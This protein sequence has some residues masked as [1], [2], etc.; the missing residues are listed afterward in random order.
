VKVEIITQT[1]LCYYIYIYILYCWSYDFCLY[2]LYDSGSGIHNLHACTGALYE[3]TKF[4]YFFFLTNLI[5]YFCLLSFGDCFPYSMKFMFHFLF[6][7]I[8]FIMMVRKRRNQPSH[9]NITLCTLMAVE[10][11]SLLI[12]LYLSMFFF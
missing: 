5:I 8:K 11:N 2:Y 10:G 12:L 4:R 6:Y 3:F 1:N 7:M 9:K